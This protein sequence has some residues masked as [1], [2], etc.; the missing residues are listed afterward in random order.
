M[1]S[2]NFRDIDGHRTVQEHRNVGNLVGE[3][4]LTD[5]VHQFLGAFDCKRRND[6][7]ASALDGLVYHIAQLVGDV[8]Q[9]FVIPVAIGRLHYNVVRTFK[10][11]G[12]LH[13]RFPGLPDVT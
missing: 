7:I 9:G 5:V 3:D 2:K 10:Q 4:K 12:V 11:C 6:Q 8:L 1:C 13:K